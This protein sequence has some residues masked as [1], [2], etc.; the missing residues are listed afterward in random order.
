MAMVNNHSPYYNGGR[1]GGTI[2][3]F[4]FDKFM[5]L[6]RNSYSVGKFNRAV[7]NC[8]LAV[9]HAIRENNLIGAAG[10]Y[11]LWID[12]LMKLSKYAEVK[13][14]CCDARS[15]F[16]NSIDLVYYEFIA[17]L[18]AQDRSAAARLAREFIEMQ[19]SA[20]NGERSFFNN[21]AGK[22]GEVQQALSE[23]E[24]SMNGQKGSVKP[25][26]QDVQK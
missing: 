25:E 3:R 8:R 16:G 15:K 26:K 2:G 9:E 11:E 22:I 10:A 18:S 21:T 23:L 24:A 12:S 19:K 20:N 14:I 4:G 13:K 7:D 6:A 1:K 5:Q 17:A